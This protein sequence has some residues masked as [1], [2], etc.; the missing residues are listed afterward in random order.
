ME[1]GNFAYVLYAP[2]FTFKFGVH[3]AVSVSVEWLQ[4]D[5]CI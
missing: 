4:Y 1:T 3:D 5:F 2:K